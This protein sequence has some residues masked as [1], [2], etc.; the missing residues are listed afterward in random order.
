MTDFLNG[1]MPPS[2]DKG[3]GGALRIEGR[4]FTLFVAQNTN[5]I[6][7]WAAL[8]GGVVAGLPGN[9]TYML[10]VFKGFLIFFNRKYIVF[11][12]ERS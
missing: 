11:L 9:S 10:C 8:R 6:G 2:D 4:I 12:F 3:A 5:F 7:N 1:V